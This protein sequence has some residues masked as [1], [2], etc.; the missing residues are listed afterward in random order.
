MFRTVDLPVPAAPYKTMNFCIFLESPVTIDPIAHSILC[1]SSSE[2]K[3][4]M[5]LSYACVSPGSSG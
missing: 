1:L 4:D 2:Y 5:S 3:V